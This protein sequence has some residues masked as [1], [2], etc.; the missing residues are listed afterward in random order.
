V[1]ALAVAG[2]AGLGVAFALGTSWLLSRTVLRG[3]VS[4]FSLEL[5]P[6]RPPRIG[7]TLYTSLLDRTLIVLGRAVTFALPA[8]A[9]IW[10]CA[11]VRVGEASV[12]EHVIRFLDP[13]GFWLG[14]NGVIL[15]AYIIAIPA[16]EIVIPTILM[17][18]VTVTGMTELGAGTGVMFELEDVRSLKELLARGGWTTLTAVNLMLFSL[19]HNPCSTTLYTIYKE[20]GSARWTALA[21]LLPLALGALVCAGVAAVWRAVAGG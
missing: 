4:T 15:L 2:V 9:V 20:T 12:A 5:P 8:G 16:N 18:T 11:N 7:Q 17:L 21:A 19:L 6:Y 3:E 10:L 13:V 1:A 14:L